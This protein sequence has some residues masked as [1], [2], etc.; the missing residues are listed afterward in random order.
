MSSADGGQSAS[1]EK[2]R[3]AGRLT[4]GVI[5]D[6]IRLGRGGRSPVD[7]L[8]LL[9]IIQANTAHVLAAADL[10]LTYATAETPLP[11]ELR[12]PL[13]L[14]ALAASLELPFETVRRRVNRLADEGLCCLTPNGVYVPSVRLTPPQDV[15]SLTAIYERFRLFY[16][17][18]QAIGALEGL[19]P[20]VRSSEGPPPVRAVT[21][22]FGAYLLRFVDAVQQRTGSR[23]DALLLLAIIYLNTEHLGAADLGVVPDELRRPARISDLAA[24]MAMP[25]ETVRRRVLNLI[26]QDRCERT[27]RGLIVPARVMG[28]QSTMAVLAE[29]APELQRLFYQ[30]ARL[31]ILERWDRRASE[32]GA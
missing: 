18:L 27:E 29:H 26:A 28:A 11:D 17:D 5:L 19:P 25:A 30:L 15:L 6:A 4:I 24:R 16:H 32:D 10:Q 14:S 9:T 3:V 2:I 7:A 22:L 20:A 23:L 1:V 8:L 31:G 12:R 21:R 13:S